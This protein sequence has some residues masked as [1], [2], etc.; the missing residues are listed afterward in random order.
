MR[1]IVHGRMQ[2]DDIHAAGLPF[3]LILQRGMPSDGERP[4][5]AHRGI[6]QNLR[7]ATAREV[8]MPLQSHGRKVLFALT[9]NDHVSIVGSMAH[10]QIR[11]LMQIVHR[12][13]AP[14]GDDFYGLVL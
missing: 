3:N 8:G 10:L 6:R 5:L 14:R 9:K 12:A 4:S 7:H 13:P 1:S 2:V 11:L